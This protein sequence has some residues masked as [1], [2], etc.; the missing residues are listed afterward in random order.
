MS[1]PVFRTPIFTR[2]KC[3]SA[4]AITTSIILVL[5]ISISTIA[6]TPS[7]KAHARGVTGKSSS[8]DWPT[9][10]YNNG[11]QAYNA[12]ETTLT[13]GNISGLH[14]HWQT[15]STAPIASEPI[16]ANGLIYWGS[17]DG[18]EHA[19]DPNTGK[20]AWTQNLGTTKTCLGIYSTV[21][22]ESTA[23]ITTVTINGVNTTVDFVG[24]G[25]SQV[26]ALDA[27]TGAI[28]WQ[29]V[30]GGAGSFIYSSPAV[31]NNSVYIGISSANDCPE[32]QGQFF[33]LDAATGTIQ[34]TFNGVPNGCLGGGVWSSPAIDENLQ[35]L[36]ISTANND[37]H[38]GCSGKEPYAEALVELKLTDLSVVASWKVPYKEAYGDGDFGSTPTFF[39]ASSGGTLHHMV[40]LINK[41]GYYYAFDRTNIAAGPLW[42]DLLALPGNSPEH[43]R[44]S[45]SSSVVN[46]QSIF[47]ATGAATFNG[48]TCAGSVASMKQGNGLLN[49]QKCLPAPVLAPVIAV[50]GMIVVGAGNTMYILNMLNGQPLFTYQ[51]PS[52]NSIFWG[53]ATIS[54]GILYEGN[55]DGILYAFGL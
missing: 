26:Y 49:W 42:K 36:F 53:A 23:T 46:P 34:N 43:G 9:Y 37:V 52:P 50:S 6:A 24:G 27:N 20:D 41:N 22:V 18:Y 31:Y 7:N 4:V 38:N 16:I 21:G 17:W 40:G 30:L 10:L 32:P 55:M 2:R 29:T 45:I 28:L 35:T 15:P 3:I 12:S 8:T 14:V 25:N 1:A 19:T 13:P 5:F 33:Q 39:E 54:N 44:G 51:D 11:R 48:K 47:V